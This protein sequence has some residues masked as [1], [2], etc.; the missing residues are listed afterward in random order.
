MILI[1]VGAAIAGYAFL[2]A[3][4]T[5]RFVL[6][7]RWVTILRGVALL[8]T[9]VVLVFDMSVIARLAE[10]SIEP[11]PLFWLIAIGHP[12]AGAV[13]AITLFLS[14]ARAITIRRLAYGTWLVLASIPSWSYFLLVIL[15]GLAGVGLARAAAPEGDP[16]IDLVG[17]RRPVPS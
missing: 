11:N 17:Q 2:W 10:F 4:V 16:G 3:N 9:G 12:A 14:D 6:R 1:L 13:Y 8:A 15:V 7:A 5:G